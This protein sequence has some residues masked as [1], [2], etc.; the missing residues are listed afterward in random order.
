MVKMIRNAVEVREDFGNTLS[1]KNEVL[2]AFL[3]EVEAFSV[4][5]F[6]VKSIIYTKFFFVIIINLY[7]F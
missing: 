1:G 2:R 4:K 3:N 6:H 5:D 7:K